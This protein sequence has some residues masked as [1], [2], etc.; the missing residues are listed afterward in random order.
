MIIMAG[1]PFYLYYTEQLG[2]KERDRERE[3]EGERDRE[4][5]R[6]T[7]MFYCLLKAAFGVA[8]VMYTLIL[9]IY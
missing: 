9:H 2:K 8:S 4:R 3:R 6:E 5:E 7:A 1:L